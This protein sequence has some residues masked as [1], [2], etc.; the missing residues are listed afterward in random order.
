MPEQY[1][2][3]PTRNI[4]P[5]T[6]RKDSAITPP[7]IW[8]CPRAKMRCDV[9]DGKKAKVPSKNML[10]LIDGQENACVLLP[11]KDFH[12]LTSDGDLQALLAALSETRP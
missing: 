9:L 6:Q 11:D 10:N 8:L 12:V 2:F 3:V 4:D 7:R 5:P 1:R